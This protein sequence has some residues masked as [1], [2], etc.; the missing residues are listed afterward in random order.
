MHPAIPLTGEALRGMVIPDKPN[1]LLKKS[2]QS[3]PCLHYYSLNQIEKKLR[4][5]SEIIDLVNKIH[6]NQS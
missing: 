1:T 4:L 2:K 3:S 5:T 6:S